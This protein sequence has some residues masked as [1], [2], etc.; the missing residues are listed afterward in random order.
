MKCCNDC[1]T[2]SPSSVL[3]GISS[4]SDMEISISES[5]TDNPVSH[6]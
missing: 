3:T 2:F 6:I 4:T 1:I 5:G